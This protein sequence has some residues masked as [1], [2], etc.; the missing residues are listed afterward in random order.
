MTGFVGGFIC[1]ILL[2][3]AIMCLIW[4]INE[5]NDERRR[6]QELEVEIAKM[7]ANRKQQSV[8]IK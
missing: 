2:V 8:D 5:L 7:E 1:A 6:R 4:A 3:A